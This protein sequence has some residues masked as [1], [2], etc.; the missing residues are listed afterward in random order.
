MEAL[1]TATSNPAKFLGQNDAGKV[2]PN[3][4]ADLVLLDANPLENI[5][6]TERIDAVVANGQ[7]FDRSALDHLLS[8]VAT[9]ASH[10]K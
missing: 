6:N 2:A 9:A 10:T 4:V 8:N 1:Q 7:F 3:C 5:R